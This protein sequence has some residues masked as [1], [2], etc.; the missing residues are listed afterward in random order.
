MSDF[1]MSSVQR[2][3]IFK[4]ATPKYINETENH[5]QILVV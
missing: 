1:Q 5:N 2:E 4:S 3:I